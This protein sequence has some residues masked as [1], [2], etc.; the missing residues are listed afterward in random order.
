MN[1]GGNYY[2]A[3]TAADLFELF[4][5]KFDLIFSRSRAIGGCRLA[6]RASR[7]PFATTI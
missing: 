1:G 4:V 6:H 3:A 7:L 5:E 2:Y